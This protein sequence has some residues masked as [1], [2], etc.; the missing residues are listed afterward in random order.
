[1]KT[2]NI[3]VKEKIAT[4]AAG[5]FYVCGNSDYTAVFDFDSEWD[6]YETKTARFIHGGSYT[7]V[8]F[9][10]NVCAVPAMSNVYS[11]QVG[12][13]AG[14]LRTTTPASIWTK[15]SILCDA[16]SPA[17]PPDSVYNQIMEELNR[18]DENTAERVA[19][20]IKEWPGIIP[21]D[22]M[23]LGYPYTN[24]KT[25]TI[26]EE[27]TFT[28][29]APWFLNIDTPIVAGGT[30]IIT[31]NGKEYYRTGVFNDDHER[32]T[33]RL[34][35][36]ITDGGTDPVL[37]WGSEHD[38]RPVVVFSSEESGE[39]TLKVEQVNTEYIPM[40]E[41]L[42]PVLTSPGGKKF[43]ISVNDDGTLITVEVTQ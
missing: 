27:R 26:M 10:G 20:A 17:A 40:D 33:V 41:K 13:Y 34:M 43:K 19:I 9:T 24:V 4:C 29:A 42:M 22:K 39:L 31:Y 12:V 8:V 15:K 21:Q 38:G 1:M 16:G 11:F 35:T 3:T 30:Y 7:D 36:D 18:I 32:K 5:Q 28:N 2:I 14:N 25:D 6:E 23:P 37:V